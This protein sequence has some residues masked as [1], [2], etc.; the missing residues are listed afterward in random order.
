MGNRILW[1]EMTRTKIYNIYSRVPYI[2][3][4]VTESVRVM[5][6][7][8]HGSGLGSVTVS[9]APRP[10]SCRLAGSTR[11]PVATPALRLGPTLQNTCAQQSYYKYLGCIAITWSPGRTSPDIGNGSMSALVEMY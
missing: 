6:Q 7:S 5:L 11:T 10:P 4:L 9:S 1:K 3:E 2:P 8:P